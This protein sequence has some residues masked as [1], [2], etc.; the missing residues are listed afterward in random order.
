[1]TVLNPNNTNWSN[2]LLKQAI[3][4]LI[5]KL[6]KPTKKTT[7]TDLS[8]TVKYQKAAL[9][10]NH[11]LVLLIFLSNNTEIKIAIDKSK[12]AI[13]GVS[14]EHSLQT[15]SIAGQMQ[16]FK[17]PTIK[18]F[19]L[20]CADYANDIITRAHQQKAAK[21]SAKAAEDTMNSIE[22]VVVSKQDVENLGF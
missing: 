9:S 10:D 19:A 4:G 7:T 16:Y 13:L 22:S 2:F 5:L 17:M 11:Q 21:E 1:M 20:D 15:K 6:S 18:S 14:R 8:A 3:S 12:N